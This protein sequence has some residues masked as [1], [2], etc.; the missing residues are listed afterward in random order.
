[1]GLVSLGVLSAVF[2]VASTVQIA[3]G[4][5]GGPVI[6]KTLPP[7]CEATVQS[8]QGSLRQAFLAALDA[9]HGKELQAYD[10]GTAPVVKLLNETTL[11][12]CGPGWPTV[13]R[14]TI[15]LHSQRRALLTHH[16]EHVV[17]LE[18]EVN[19]LS[20]SHRQS[21]EHHHD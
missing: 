5:Y 9:E 18:Q 12:R 21:L 11:Q 19:R 20:S 1:M 3:T 16:V 2:I 13:L 4:A 7:A 8:A 17:P 10:N 6:V 15:E 14:A